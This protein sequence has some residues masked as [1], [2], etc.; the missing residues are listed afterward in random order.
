MAKHTTRERGLTWTTSPPSEKQL[1][2]DGY[3]VVQFGDIRNNYIQP[4]RNVTA[5]RLT[6]D[7]AAATLLRL[8]DKSPRLAVL[9]VPANTVGDL[10]DIYS[11]LV[12]PAF[13]RDIDLLLGVNRDLED[14]NSASLVAPDFGYP[15]TLERLH[16]IA[17]RYLQRSP[18][19]G[20]PPLTPIE[21]QLLVAM[22]SAGLTPQVQYGIERFRVDFAFVPERLIVEADGRAWHDAERDAARDAHLETLG[23]KTI[24]FSGSEIYRDVDGVVDGTIAALAGQPKVIAFTDVTPAQ[25][26]VSLWQRILNWF[27]RSPVAK[28]RD[29]YADL[30]PVA[31]T[32]PSWKAKLDVDQRRAVDSMEGVVQVIAP[33]GSGKTTTMIARVQELLSRG[34]PANRILCTTFNKATREELQDRL[35]ELSIVGVD[36][37][38]FHALGRFI[39]K[40][41]DQLRSDIGTIS[42]AQWRRLA[43]L[44]M[45]NVNGVWLDA[46]VASEAVSN[47]KLAEMISPAESAARARTP[48]QATAA[49]IYR[50]YEDHL[51]EADRHDF[52][53]L[54]ISSV[55]LLQTNADVRQRWQDKWEAILVDEYQDIEPAQE[56]LIQMIAAPDDSIFAVGDEDQCIYAWRRATVER[57]VMLDTVYPG[58]ERTVLTTSYRA[59]SIDWCSSMVS[60]T[61]PCPHPPRPR[62]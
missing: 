53:D 30:P 37:K 17:Q 16:F 54:I 59:S 9:S 33:A 18:M 47:Y 28:P 57:I 11:F 5:K 31:R 55:Q 43:M 8:L 15:W 58:L 38:N 48:V 22:K 40:E 36:V 12:E 21:E 34:I 51:E 49:E 2:N 14:L 19:D 24:R 29:P 1:R 13:H 46:P 39:L 62:H 35:K 60:S 10:R 26:K 52:D 61:R 50:L 27:R 3:T 42:Y 32:I 41:E 45:N 56:L 4:T 7:N 6:L 44:A 20:L 25:P 23:W